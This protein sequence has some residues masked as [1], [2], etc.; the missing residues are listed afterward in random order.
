MLF[1]AAK[2]EFLQY[3]AHKQA[4][5]SCGSGEVAPSLASTPL[6]R[7]PPLAPP[8]PNIAAGS[9]ACWHNC[10]IYSNALR[11]NDRHIYVDVD[12]KYIITN[13]VT[14]TGARHID[15]MARQTI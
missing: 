15:D 10:Q 11:I 1:S 4:W 6:P 3:V 14:E 13:Y 7:P 5:A 2:T 9:T 8:S 12:V